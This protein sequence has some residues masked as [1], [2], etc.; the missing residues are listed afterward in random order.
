M[1]N[2]NEPEFKI[3]ITSAQDVLT[4]SEGGSVTPNYTYGEF[5]TPDMNI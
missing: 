5:E 3:V 2:Y 4:A 1:K